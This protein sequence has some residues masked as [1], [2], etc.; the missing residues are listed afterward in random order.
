MKYSLGGGQ[1]AEI[2]NASSDPRGAWS[3]ADGLW[4][5]AASH[6]TWTPAAWFAPALVLEAALDDPQVAME[7]LGPTTFEGKTVEHL[8]F[9]RVPPATS[10]SPA[11]IAMIQRLSTA[12]LYVDKTSLLP[13]ALDFNLHPNSNAGTNIPVEIR[14]SHWEQSSGVLAPFL[15]QKFLNGSLLDRISVSSAAVNQGLSSSSFAIPEISG[16]T[17]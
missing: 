17:Q 16:G 11:A 12:D 4:H 5:R 2:F 14:Y 1:R 8:R 15:I 9:Q 10:G 7:D 6:N 13:V 3:G